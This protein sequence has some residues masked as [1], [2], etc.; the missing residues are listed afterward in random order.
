[1]NV[2]GNPVKVL[3]AEVAGSI[4]SGGNPNAVLFVPQTLTEAEKATAQANIGAAGKLY[5]AGVFGELKSALQEM[6]IDG[7]VA[8]LDQAILDLSV[9]A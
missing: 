5:I 7:A 2:T 6:D 3:A 8:I 1:M 4:P 9:L